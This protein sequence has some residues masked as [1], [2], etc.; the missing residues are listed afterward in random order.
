MRTDEV[1]TTLKIFCLTAIALALSACGRAPVLELGQ[2]ASYVER[3]EQVSSKVGKPVKVTDL[4]VRFGSPEEVGERRDGVCETGDFI[5]PTV[6]LNVRNW[7]RMSEESREALMFHELGHCVLFRNHVSEYMADA[8]ASSTESNPGDSQ[9]EDGTK[10]PRS[11]MYP[12][13]LNP[14]MYVDHRDHYHHEL[15]GA[16]PKAPVDPV[17]PPSG[18]TPA[19]RTA[20]GSQPSVAELED[21]GCVRRR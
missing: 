18:S 6:I 17:T 16:D 8:K 13:A 20:L 1:K 5:P 19:A 21:S 11:L 15:F 3:F 4:V 14:E 9:E 7:G 10:V 12:I 2:F